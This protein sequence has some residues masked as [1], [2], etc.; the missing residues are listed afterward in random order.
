MLFAMIAQERDGCLRGFLVSY[1]G[2]YPH[3]HNMQTTIRRTAGVLLL[4]SFGAIPATHAYA[5]G[6]DVVPIPSPTFRGGAPTDAT[7]LRVRAILGNAHRYALTTWWQRKGF[8]RQKG[9][10]VSF[11]GTGE[12]QIRPSAHEAFALAVALKTGAYDAEHTGVSSAVAKERALRLTRSLAYRH[13]ANTPRGWGHHWQSALWA[14]SAGT[15]GWLLWDDLAPRDRQYVQRM[16]EQ[17][18]NRFI[19]YRPPYYRDRSGTILFTGDT[20]AEENAWNGRILQLATAMMPEHPRH[21]AWQKTM[22]DLMLSAFARPQDMQSTREIHGRSLAEWL[23]GSNI[24]DD[25]SMVNH[26]RVHPDYFTN[27]TDNMYAALVY[28]LAGLPIPEAAFFNADAVYTALVNTPFAGKTIY[29]TNEG[30]IHYPQG[31]R[32][33]TQRR[34]HFAL[35][36]IQAQVF[37]FDWNAKKNGAYWEPLHSQRVL[38]MQK[39]STDGRTYASR[40]EDSYPGREEWVADLA[41]QAYLT[42]WLGSRSFYRITSEPEFFSTTTAVAGEES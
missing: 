9:P 27:V 39:R 20:K 8:N 33:G 11:G 37:G 2:T 29:Q 3:R 6:N 19:G 13:V 5:A 7:T 18:A 42:T 40:A 22:V 12:Q 25:G 36:D 34:M 31:T 26:N 28:T 35:L 16:V 15:A 24:N 1:R 23:H 21:S 38:D 17:E 4:V 41:A 10:Y 30:I 14:S 32:W